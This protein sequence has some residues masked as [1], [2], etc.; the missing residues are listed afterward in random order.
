MKKSVSICAFLG[1]LLVLAAQISAQ[2]MAGAKIFNDNC[3]VCHQNGGNI[4]IP[5]MPL[6]GSLKLASLDTFLSFIRDPRMP[7]GSKGSM[8]AFSKEQISDGK[9]KELYEYITSKQ[10]LD[11]M[12]RGQQGWYCPYC[13]QY[14][15]TYGG[16]GMGP[17]MMGGYGM[18][19]GMMG[20][21]YGMGPGMM[22]GYGGGY[23]GYGMGPGYYNQSEECQKFLDE[24]SGLRKELHDKR[25]E[26]MEALRN[27]KTTSETDARLRKEIDELQQEIYKKTPLGCRY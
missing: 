6:R 1:F 24:T 18:G 22:G 10:G 26:Y 23:G 20:G 3:K 16:Y 5:G 27:P 7:D 19:P 13:G 11:L 2:E 8:P 21:G 4:I 12:S 15:G 17:G 9:A 14:M 25:F